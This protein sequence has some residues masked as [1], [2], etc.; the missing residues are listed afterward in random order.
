MK[1]IILCTLAFVLLTLGATKRDW[2]TGRVA[3]SVAG[4]SVRETG[5][6][7]TASTSASTIGTISPDYGAGSTL[8]AQTTA[9][10]TA[11]TRVRYITT[12]EVTVIGESYVYQLQDPMRRGGGLLTNAIANRKHGCRFIVGADVQYAQ[13]K[14]KLYVLDADGKECKLDIARQEKGS[15]GS[16]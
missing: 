14:G 12:N 9:T 1:K 3:D 8:D 6:T 11:T 15:S 5:S 2:K 13:E 7:T 16:R 10:S 4:S